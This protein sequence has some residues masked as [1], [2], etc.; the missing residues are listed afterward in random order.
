MEHEPLIHPPHDTEVEHRAE[1]GDRLAHRVALFT[2]LLAT[3]G[4]IISFMG[5]H[6][7][8]KAL[9]YKNEASV[10]KTEAANQWS[11]FQAKAQRENLAILAAEVVSDPQ[12]Q[13]RYR[14]DAERYAKER[15]E[16]RVRA[17]GFEK[18][19]R[20][21]DLHAESELR[22]YERF[23]LSIALLQIA[24]ALASITVLTRRN[25]LMYVAAGAALLGSGIGLLAQFL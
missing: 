14:A 2:A 20:E 3:V 1:H 24:I 17:E 16:V 6:S 13:A 23:G 12:K 4:A 25:W 8:N 15:E 9:Y 22:P 10:K 18:E 11:Y 19:F 5:G 21:T 7:I